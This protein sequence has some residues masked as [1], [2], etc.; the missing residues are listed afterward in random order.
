MRTLEKFGVDKEL[1]SENIYDHIIPALAA[2]NSIAD[3]N[4]ERRLCASEGHQ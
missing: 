4:A 1:G 3:R 2:A